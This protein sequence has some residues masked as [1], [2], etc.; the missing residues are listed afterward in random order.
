VAEHRTE[1]WHRTKCNE[2]EVLDK[3]SGYKDRL[4]KEAIEKLH[5]D[6]INIEEGFKLSTTENLGASLYRHCHAHTS[7]KSKK[8]RRACQKENKKLTTGMPG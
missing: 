5:P 3:T 4:V 6:N 7:R 1:T 8:D 2:T